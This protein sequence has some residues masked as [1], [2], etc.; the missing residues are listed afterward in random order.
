MEQDKLEI[1][2]QLLQIHYYFTDESHSMDAFVRNAMEKDLLNLI[3]EIANILDIKI[4]VENQAREEGGLIESLILH[5]DSIATTSIAIGVAIY[6][7]ESVNKII[8]HYFTGAYKR[9]KLE[10]LL[11]KEQIKELQLKNNNDVLTELKKI[12]QGFDRSPKIR[13][14]MSNFYNKA[15]KC[16]KI[17]K[18]GYKTEKSS[19]LLVKREQFKTFILTENKDRELIENAEI[20]IISPVLKEGKYKWRGIYNGNKID[21]SMGDSGFKNDVITQ[22]HNFINGTSIICDLEISRTFDEYGEE[23]KISYKVKKVL[24][25]RIGEVLK[26]TKLGKKIKRQKQIDNEPTLFDFMTDNHKEQ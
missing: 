6:L 3:N 5:F 22:K 13:R 17:E 19:E 9:E 7:K 26:L 10:N 11:K 1:E 20:E 8:I 4:K 14:I 18:I 16:E 25:I 23:V 24:G 15:E 12:L 21:F 2:K